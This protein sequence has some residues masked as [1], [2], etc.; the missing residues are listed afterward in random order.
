[1][2]KSNPKNVMYKM[3]ISIELTRL[4]MLSPLN[5]VFGN[6]AKKETCKALG[7]Y[8]MTSITESGV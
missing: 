3:V 1:M 2:K 7:V 6:G 5:Q 8:L 4:K